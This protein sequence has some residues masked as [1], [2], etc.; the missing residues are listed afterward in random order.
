MGKCRV[1]INA[2]AL[3]RIDDKAKEALFKTAEAVKTDIVNKGVVPFDQ[4]TL[5]NT[6]FVDKK[7]DGSV[8]IVNDTPYARRL[9][10]H[11]EYDF[12]TVNNPNAGSHWFEPWIYG[13]YKNFAKEAFIKFM[14]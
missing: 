12:Q 6:M 11:P 7:Q 10:Y 13:K 3:K 9:Y 14:K 2:S 4:G 1:I 8:S 5:Q